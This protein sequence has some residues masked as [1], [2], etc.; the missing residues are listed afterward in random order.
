MVLNLNDHW[1][2]TSQIQLQVNIYGSHGYHKPTYNIHT[3]QRERNTNIPVKK[4]IKSQNRVSCSVVSD[5]AT[6]WIVCSPPGSLAM[7]F[8]RQEY[9]SGLPFLS[10]GALPDPGIEPWVSCTAGRFFTQL[11]RAIISSPCYAFLILCQLS[12][13]TQ[14]THQSLP[15]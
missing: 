15:D 1:F 13:L 14:K 4:I 8:P 7:G 10:P 3:N 11:N 2:K 12:A 9:W 6:P 5:S